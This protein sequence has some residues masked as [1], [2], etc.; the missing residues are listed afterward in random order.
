MHHNLT[1]SRRLVT[2]VILSAAYPPFRVARHPPHYHGLPTERTD[3]A[4]IDKR[5]DDLPLVV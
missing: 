3:V 2:G 4:S 5:N 1:F